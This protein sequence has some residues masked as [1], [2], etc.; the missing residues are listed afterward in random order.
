MALGSI[1]LTTQVPQGMRNHC[2]QIII[3]DVI[4]YN[5]S[6]SKFTVTNLVPANLAVSDFEPMGADAGGN[7]NNIGGQNKIHLVMEFWPNG[8]EAAL[9][10][11]RLQ[12]DRV[13][14][15][16]VMGQSGLY[17]VCMHACMYT[18]ADLRSCLAGNLHA[19]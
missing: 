6:F 3:E 10:E 4:G 7:K 2:L 8:K 1:T 18:H 14:L 13:G 12:L 11:W 5:T 15:L 9:A 19:H 16:G 17:T